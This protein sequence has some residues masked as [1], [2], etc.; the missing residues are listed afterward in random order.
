SILIFLTILVGLEELKTIPP[1]VII[2]GTITILMMNILYPVIKIFNQLKSTIKRT[3]NREDVKGKCFVLS[4]NREDVKGK[5]FVLS[6]NR[7]DVK[8]KC[9]VLSLVLSFIL[10][11]LFSIFFKDISLLDKYMKNGLI[12]GV[13]TSILLLNIAILEINNSC[14]KREEEYQRSEKELLEKY[15]DKETI[16]ILKAA[17]NKQKK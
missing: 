10:A 8:G 14:L 4:F 1:I 6:F 15:R 12:W 5:C 11:I 2:I 13:N 16:R 9:F 17:Q 3:I 7:E